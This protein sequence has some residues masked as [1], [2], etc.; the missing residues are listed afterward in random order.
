MIGATLPPF[1]GALPNTPL[2]NY[3]QPNKDQLRKKINDWIRTSQTFDGVLDLDQGLKDS[4]HPDRL[5]P[6]YDSGDHLHPNDHGNQQM[7][8]LVHLNQLINK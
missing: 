7:A 2:D 4:K 5:N 3:Y 6:I 8:N 1:S